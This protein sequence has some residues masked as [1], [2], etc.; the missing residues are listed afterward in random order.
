MSNVANSPTTRCTTVSVP[1]AVLTSAA[2]K[3]AASPVSAGMLRAVVMT[4]APAAARRVTIGG[5]DALLPPVTR[6]RRPAR[7]S[8]TDVVF[9]TPTCGLPLGE[10][11]GARLSPRGR[12][13]TGQMQGRLSIGDFSRMSH[14]SVKTL[15]R[16][17]ESGLLEPAEVDE[18]TGY[19]YYQPGQVPVAQTIRRFRDLGMPVREIG[20]LLATIDPDQRSELIAAHLTRLETQLAQTQAAVTSLRRLL[21][22]KAAP[23]EVELHTTAAITAAAIGATVSLPDV[24]DWY[25]EAMTELDTAIAATGQSPSGPP[26]GLYDNDLFTDERGELLVFVPV[27]DPPRSG[28]VRPEVIASTNLAVT[29]HRGD[30]SDIDVTYGALG[31]WVDQHALAIAGPVHETYLVGPRDTPDSAAWRTEI[32]WP[33][34]NTGVSGQERL[35]VRGEPGA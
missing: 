5:A 28:R 22:R 1:A 11:Q 27:P 30:H 14:V 31:I 15:R 3:I 2:T 26:G 7:E 8:V 10:G 25:S 33:V 18:W 9:M 6:A 16:Y 23:I 24:L 17:H 34:S 29:V 4:M 19:R 21:D 13:H 32:G 35:E 20:E 12:P